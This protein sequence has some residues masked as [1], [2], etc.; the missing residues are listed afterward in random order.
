[1][2]FQLQVKVP[3]KFILWTASPALRIG[4]NLTDD[5][6]IRT[7]A[8]RQKYVYHNSSHSYDDND[9]DDDDGDDDD[10]ADFSLS[11][12]PTVHGVC[13]TEYTVN[14]REDIATDVSVSRDLSNC[15]SFSAHRQDVS[16]LAII[17]GMVRR[18]TL[19]SCCCRGNDM[20]RRL[21]R[22]GRIFTLA[23]VFAWPELP[24]VQDDQ[25]Q[26]DMQL[27]VRQPEEAHD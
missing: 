8:S 6:I 2:Y 1:M 20:K 23:R 25:Q 3:D 14:A 7:I 4:G 11:F 19:I 16:P 10:D 5:L 17:T 27:Q 12:Q 15:D 22:G 26:P 9:D 18:Q 13:P 24:S 21:D